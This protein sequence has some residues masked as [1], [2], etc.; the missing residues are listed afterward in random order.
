MSLGCF[1]YLVRH[2][3]EDVEDLCGSLT[4][5]HENFLGQYPYPVYV[6][7]EPELTKDLGD[8][9]RHHV[10]APTLIEHA[11]EVPRWVEDAPAD[12]RQLGY[13]HMCRFFGNEIFFQEELWGHRY[14]CRLDSDSRILSPVGFDLFERAHRGRWF[15]GYITD[16]LKDKPHYA[17]GLWKACER[18]FDGFEQ[19]HMLHQQ[20]AD[21]PFAQCYYTNFELCRT[22][23]F[24]QAPWTDFFRYLD[25]DGGI[26]RER[27]G[28]HT[29]RYIGVRMFMD[30][31][32]IHQFDDI[33]YRHHK[34]FNAPG[35]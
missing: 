3:P 2:T 12:P 22:S 20:F 27:W 18:Y 16:A 34:T 8:Q 9:I 1:C 28:D 26:Y 11:F 13:R 25:R 19:V 17:Q 14:Y 15:Y 7:H 6:F 29:I 24:Q 35:G 23:W 33:H 4:S 5:L 30:P 21:L 10:A 31:R 32:H